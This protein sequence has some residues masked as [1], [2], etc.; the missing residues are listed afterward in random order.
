M[1]KCFIPISI[2]H[3]PSVSE[4]SQVQPKIN[5]AYFPWRTQDIVPKSKWLF[6]TSSHNIRTSIPVLVSLPWQWEWKLKSLSSSPEILS[7]LK[8]LSRVLL[9]GVKAILF[10]PP[11]PYCLTE[12]MLDEMFPVTLHLLTFPR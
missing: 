7:F 12:E 2:N 6:L 5:V 10:S 4:I 9:K 8:D 3:T 11:H 1:N